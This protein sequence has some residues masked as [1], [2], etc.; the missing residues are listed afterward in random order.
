MKSEDN[1]GS[2][3]MTKRNNILLLGDESLDWHV[4]KTQGTAVAS[5]RASGG[6]VAA[7]SG[8]VG[9]QRRL[10][11]Q[12]LTCEIH[13]IEKTDGDVLPPQE[14]SL[15]AMSLSQTMTICGMFPQDVQSKNEVL[16]IDSLCG[17][18]PAQQLSANWKAKVATCTPQVVIVDDANL[19]IRTQVSELVRIVE[20]LPKDETGETPWIILKVAW[21][22]LNNELLSVF[23]QNFGRKLIVLVPIDDLRR[24]N[25][26]I[27]RGLSWERTAQD[28]AWEF[29]YNPR[30][31]LLEK[32]HALVVPVGLSGVWLSAAQQPLNRSLGSEHLSSLVY[33]PAS[34][35]GDWEKNRP[36][37]L[38]G[39]TSCLSVGI[40]QEILK[41]RIPNMLKAA[42][43]GLSAMRALHLNGYCVDKQRGT[44]ELPFAQ[45]RQAIEK[46]TDFSSVSVP[47]GHRHYS[48]PAGPAVGFRRPAAWSILRASVGTSSRLFDL[49]MS[50]VREGAVKSL[51]NI[52]Y[53]RFGGLLTVDRNEIEAFRT[54]YGLI[55]DYC[56]NTTLHKP[57]SIAVF[58]PPGSG[59]SFGVAQVAKAVA[60]GS[61]EK[62]TFNVSQFTRNEDL[63][64]AFHR[65]RD[66]GLA[67]KIPLV[68]WDEFD[69]TLDG[70]KLHWLKAFLAPMQDGEFTQ[71]Q[72]THPIGRAIFVFA[73]GTASCVEQLGLELPEEDKHSAKVPDFKSRLRGCINMVGIDRAADKQGSTPEE[74]ET[75]PQYL[76]RRAVILRSII[77]R[78]R[79]DVIAKDGRANID[80]GLLKALLSIWSFRH[81][82]R[83]LESIVE[84]CHLGDAGVLHRS[85]LPPTDVLALH[86]DASR[87]LGLITADVEFRG[88]TLETLAAAHHE[89]YR[90]KSPQSR[91]AKMS[92]AELKDEDKEKN[93]IAVR[94][95]PYKLAAIG[96]LYKLQQ[97]DDVAA[98]DALTEDEAIQLGRL[99]HDRW[100]IAT[101]DDGYVYGEKRED[102]KAPKQHPDLV[103]WDAVTGKALFTLYPASIASR[104]GEGPLRNTVDVEMAKQIPEI[105]RRGGYTVIRAS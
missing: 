50:I 54:T 86:V 96:F 47:L 101:M 24:D 19:G 84:L 1:A 69:S 73:G 28:I 74:S 45:I 97:A 5:W 42:C 39:Y 71:G 63:V 59:K 68:F 32:I 95:I 18:R 98:S 99:E 94:G 72:V 87:F 100:L 104:L 75:D 60:G 66:I 44:V 31:K 40:L 92:Y 12:C 82:V 7:A 80:E 102:V 58:G 67:G 30:M 17:F 8:G 89:L 16:R 37:T 2:L 52:P 105:M 77:E 53:A 15:R 13:P 33:D 79:P 85:S 90:M 20:S 43:C 55:Q 88:Q 61:I 48:V 34:I 83:S 35:E 49:A 93:R 21:P 46:P 26:Q 41:E 65:V 91:L 23:A 57:L 103:P 70:S 62:I 51:G 6:I 9:L 76:V 64:D 14:N 4:I 10:I 22:I 25:V 3:D 29:T 27:S 36:G 78:I 11:D 38:L 81:G 56:R